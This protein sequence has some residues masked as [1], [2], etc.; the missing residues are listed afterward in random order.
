MFLTKCCQRQELAALLHGHCVLI[1]H[2]M[3]LVLS[4]HQDGSRMELAQCVS[5]V[6]TCS[7]QISFIR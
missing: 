5:P 3:T 7:A 6:R 2:R 1:Q 4:H